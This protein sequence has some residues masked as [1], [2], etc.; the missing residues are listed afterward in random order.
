MRTETRKQRQLKKLDKVSVMPVSIATMNFGKDANVAYVIR[1]AACFGASEV[2]IVGNTALDRHVLNAV[3]GSTA[4]LVKINFFSSEQEFLKYINKN[5]A[6]LVSFELPGEWHDSVSI[7]EFSFS[8]D[9]PTCIV[10]GHETAGVPVEILMNSQCIYVPM[11]GIGYCL[12][13][14]QA[15]NVALYEASKQYSKFKFAR[16]PGLKTS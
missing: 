5:N 4:D 8:F 9:R 2:N 14:S 12:N 7:D 3:S 11:P 15:A 6:Q 10:V 16:R 1:A 13:T